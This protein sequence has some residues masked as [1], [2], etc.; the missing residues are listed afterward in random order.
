MSIHL[1]V[2]D[3][4]K[5]C[6]VKPAGGKSVSLPVLASTAEAGSDAAPGGKAHGKVKKS[7]KS[8]W[9]AVTLIAVHVAMGL[10][11]LQW[12]RDGV[13]VSP[14]EPSESMYALEAGDVNAGFIF[15]IC[16]IIATFFLG[17]L[18]CGWGCHIIALQDLCSTIMMKLGVRPK[19]FRSR[20]LL[21]VPLI[22]AIYMFVWPTVR[23][24]GLQRFVREGTQIAVSQMAGPTFAQ[25][26]AAMLREETVKYARAPL[27]LWMGQTQPFPGFR[28]A[29]VK[30]NFWETFAPWYIA[31]PF[32]GFCCFAIVYFLGNKGFCTYGCP[33]G[34]FFGPIDRV[35]IGRIVVN[36]KCEGCGHCT[37]VCTSNVRVHQEVRDYGQ[38]V[39]PGCMKCLDCVSVCPNEALSYKLGKPAFLVQPRTEEARAGKV[40]KPDYDLSLGWELAAGVL[41]L[42]F[43]LAF[44]G[45]WNSVPML[46][47][48]AMA[49]CLT[50]CVWKV[51]QMATVANV[52]V[53]SLQMR[54]KGKA[55]TAGHVFV[56]LTVA[57]VAV[58]GWCG[59]VR[60]MQAYAEALDHR[61]LTPEEVVFSPRYVPDAE[62][63]AIAQRAI[64]VMT[65]AGAREDGGWGWD[66]QPA[67]L[68][69]LGW[70]AA[71]AGDLPKAQM[72][73]RRALEGG[74]P[75]EAMVVGFRRVLALQGKTNT[76]LNTAMAEV[77][78]KRPDADNVRV[79]GAFGMLQQGKRAEFE[80][81][82]SKV[83]DRGRHGDAQAQRRAIETLAQLAANEG[84][85]QV[86]TDVTQRLD[87]LM[88]QRP[89]VGG[90]REVRAG[91]AAGQG[92]WAGAEKWLREAIEHGPRNVS[93]WKQLEQVLLQL[94]REAEAREAGRTAAT[95]AR[96]FA[97]W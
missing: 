82:L 43:F 11:L 10:H 24:E 93:Y 8:K 16:A 87:R 37:A 71:V 56:A 23:R 97:T 72:Y 7:S 41:F 76:D 44:R 85:Q 70:L 19:P 50:F 3:R 66:L 68:T 51:V 47:A 5:N 2:S 21:W 29:L 25:G 49:G 31:I 20:L 79:A 30:E 81:E 63:K 6:H 26:S 62:Q 90:L 67:Q 9:R 38:V 36:D 64:E 60:G 91:F 32:L 78:A 35:S 4:E 95:H 75:N 45:A 34:G 28:N 88:E 48:V 52:R 1:S 74:R 22:L 33:Y 94:G 13:T 69:R 83:L 54:I 39:D 18:F 77:L 80:A 73:L 59:W 57:S 42:A 46:M 27:P 40:R 61:V 86:F 65:Q 53:Q 14:V 89:S 17:R 96:R 55:T 58:A 15:F 12:V 84:N 92:D